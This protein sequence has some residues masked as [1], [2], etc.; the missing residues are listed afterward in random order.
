MRNE[1]E[2]MD[3]IMNFV[4]TDA[5]IRAAVLNGSRT[6][7]NVKR[8]IFQDYDVACYVKRVEPYVKDRAFLDQFGERMIMQ[9]PEDMA[10]PPPEDDGHYVYLM[11]FADGNRIDLSFCPL[12]SVVGMIHDSL[13]RVLVDKDG[14]IGELPP[15]SDRDYLPEEPTA[16]SY[17]D[18]CDEFWW[19][20]P[21]AAKGLWR[22]ELTYAKFMMDSVLRGQL[23]K[24][25]TWYFGIGTGFKKSHGKTGKYIK[26]DI[27]PALWSKLEDTYSDANFENIWESLFAMGDLFR[28]T[29]RYVAD[30][31]GFN[32]PEQADLRV[33]KHLRHVRQLPGDSEEIY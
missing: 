13:T 1:K 27:E 18:C 11:Q 33:S 28:I 20:C 12:D 3:L 8:D 26:D 23:M 2:M 25:L 24:M 31:Y 6:N 29:G 7:P 17:D 5:N 21:Y 30:T 22:E 14:M 10:D 15:P 4:T 9:V 32:Y 19:V 16:K